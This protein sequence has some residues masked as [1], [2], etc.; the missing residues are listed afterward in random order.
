MGCMDNL[1]KSVESV[2]DDRHMIV[3]SNRSGVK[4][5]CSVVET[6]GMLTC[7]IFRRNTATTS[8]LPDYAPCDGCGKIMTTSTVHS[9][10]DVPASE[11]FI[12]GNHRFM[13]TDDLQVTPLTTLTFLAMLKKLGINDVSS[14]KEVMVANIGRHEV[15]TN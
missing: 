3:I 13:I 2:D 7:V 5:C 9:Y 1:Y 12:K 8:T 4:P 15:R 10:S 14:L 11:T 6:L